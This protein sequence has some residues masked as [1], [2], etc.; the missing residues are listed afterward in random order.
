MASGRQPTLQWTATPIRV[1]RAL[2]QW[3]TEIKRHECRTDVEKDL[4]GIRK[5][6]ARGGSAQNALYACVKFSKN[7]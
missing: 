6:E 2:N 1:Q 3:V 4:E 5:R 7:K